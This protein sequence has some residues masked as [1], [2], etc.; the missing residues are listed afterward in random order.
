MATLKICHCG[1][2]G[3]IVHSDGFQGLEF[4]FKNHARQIILEGIDNEIFSE[5]EAG[6]IAAAIDSASLPVFARDADAELLWK[7]ECV[8]TYRASF[9]DPP[10]VPD[11]HQVLQS[12]SPLPVPPDFIQVMDQTL[13]GSRQ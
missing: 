3:R 6:R 5:E 9:E 7:M 1:K 13:S 4:G 10:S 2:H 12:P 11:I 8:N